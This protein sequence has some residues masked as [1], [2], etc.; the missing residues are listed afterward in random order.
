MT[1]GLFGNMS[2][3]TTLH[4]LLAAGCS[5]GVTSGVFLEGMSKMLIQTVVVC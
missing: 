5:L 1:G 3:V 2:E 4:R